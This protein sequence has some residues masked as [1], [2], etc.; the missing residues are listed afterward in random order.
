MT[1]ILSAKFFHKEDIGTEVQ[2]SKLLDDINNGYDSTQSTS[3]T[4]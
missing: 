4:N 3:A 1:Q 2:V